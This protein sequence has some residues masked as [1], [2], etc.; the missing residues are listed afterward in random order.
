MIDIIFSETIQSFF[1]GL[2]QTLLSILFSSLI[3]IGIILIFYHF[4]F[5]YMLFK[6]SREL[7]I[8]GTW[9][10]WIPILNFN[11]IFMC[12]NVNPFLT[13]ITILLIIPGIREFVSLALTCLMMYSFYNIAKKRGYPAITGL[14]VALPFFNIILLVMYTFFPKKDHKKKKK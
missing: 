10:S 3:I 2:G 7:K 8:K 1:Q 11:V 4:L 9:L 6:L 13:L 14:L 12:G 5:A